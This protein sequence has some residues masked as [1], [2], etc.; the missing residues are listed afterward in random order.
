MHF[1][2]RHSEVVAHDLVSLAYQL[3]IAVFDSVVYH[4]YEMSRAV[5][6]YPV[7]A[8]SSVFNL[9]ADVLEN[10]LNSFPSC[11]RTSGHHGR[12][13]ER[14][15]S[16][17]GNSCSYVQHTALFYK[18]ASSLSV[19]EMRVAAVDDYITLVEKRKQ[20][21]Y[22]FVNGRACANHH[23]NNSRFFEVLYKLFK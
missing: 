2:R 22:S 9:C 23:H 20:L 15:L 7:A 5:L 1:V 21:S 10:R 6:A 14:A 16:T 12:T 18:F 17:A 11:G 13:Y 3:H 19:R 8:G 4:L